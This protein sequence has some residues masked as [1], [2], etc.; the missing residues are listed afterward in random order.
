MR[1]ELLFRLGDRVCINL[2]VV[3]ILVVSRL[4]VSFP[5]VKLK[6]NDDNRERTC[7]MLHSQ[8]HG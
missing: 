7:G 3:F 2:G 5:G 4:F 6:E 1:D 8:I